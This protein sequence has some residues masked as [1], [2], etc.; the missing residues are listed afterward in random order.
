MLTV[1]PSSVTQA[2]SEIGLYQQSLVEGNRVTPRFFL[3]GYSYLGEKAGL[4]GFA[5]GEKQYVSSVAGLFYN[6]FSFGE[7][8][9]VFEVGVAAGAEILSSEG[10][11]GRTI[12]PRLASTVFV[13]SDALFSEIYY[14]NGTSREGWLRVDILWQA[15]KHLAIGLLHQTNDGTGP[16]GVL[17]IPQTPLRIWVS[18]MFG[19]D[20][21]VLLGG[22]I[23]F[24][25]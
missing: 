3:Q 16:R 4:W 13:G 14:E 12:N 22:E 15:T 19:K 2:Q 6:L 7:S 17:S 9:A 8:G 1:F 18:P 23:V 20:Q 24:R 11:V 25:K 5:Y 10:Q 21:K